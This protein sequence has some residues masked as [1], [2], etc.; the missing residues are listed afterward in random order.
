MLNL[1][2]SVWDAFAYLYIVQEPPF[3]DGM[4]GWAL[5]GWAREPRFSCFSGGYMRICNDLHSHSSQ[6]LA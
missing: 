4:M 6:Q 2:A 1:S 5:M 3:F